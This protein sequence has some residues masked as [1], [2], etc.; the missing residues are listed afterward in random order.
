MENR[1][2]KKRKEEKMG[3]WKIESTE[4]TRYG[5]SVKAELVASELKGMS[6]KR[7]RYELDQIERMSHL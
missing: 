1:D 3:T 5:V 4:G 6:E 2:N 7:I